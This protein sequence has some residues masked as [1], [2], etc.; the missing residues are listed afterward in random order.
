VNCNRQWFAKPQLFQSKDQQGKSGKTPRAGSSTGRTIRHDTKLQSVKQCQRTA[1]FTSELTHNG[2]CAAT[3]K[4]RRKEGLDGDRNEHYQSG[5]CLGFAP[6]A[7]Q[8]MPIMGYVIGQ[9]LQGNEAIS[10]ISSAL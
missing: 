3:A 4:S 1:S 8:G 6:E 5:S 9:K 10:L 7:F 2:F